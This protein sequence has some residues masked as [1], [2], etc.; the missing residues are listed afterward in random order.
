MAKTPGMFGPTTPGTGSF[1]E[2]A[3]AAPNL[4]ASANVKK[5]R[6]NFP[7][8]KVHQGAIPVMAHKVNTAS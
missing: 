7:N 2:T 1:Q 3:P 4:T 8:P 5:A 6:T